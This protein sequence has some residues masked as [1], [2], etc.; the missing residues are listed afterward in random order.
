[1][2]APATHATA[3]SSRHGHD[4]GARASGRRQ[5]D[6]R[7]RAPDHRRV[8]QHQRELDGDPSPR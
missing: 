4:R 7:R 2:T 1:M 8:Q 6:D 3:A 5:A